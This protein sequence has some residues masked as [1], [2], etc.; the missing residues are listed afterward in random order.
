MIMH[1]SW[2]FMPFFRYT[3]RMLLFSRISPAVVSKADMFYI[4][5][6][7]VDKSMSN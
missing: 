2:T 7:A 6:V 4:M 1:F 3:A 5:I